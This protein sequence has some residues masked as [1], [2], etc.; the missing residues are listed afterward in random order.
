MKCKDLRIQRRKDGASGRRS[1]RE[2]SAG[3][4]H[5][6][7]QFVPRTAACAPKND[8]GRLGSSGNSS[9]CTKLTYLTSSTACVANLKHKLMYSLEYI[10]N[11]FSIYYYCLLYT[12]PS[13]R[14][15]TRSRM[16]SSA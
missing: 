16:P 12:S 10:S 11:T 13:P 8:Q 1:F 4:C 9:Q 3:R 6:H 15:R 7:P 2:S 5:R 14:D